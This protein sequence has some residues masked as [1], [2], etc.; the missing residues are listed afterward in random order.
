MASALLPNRGIGSQHARE[1]YGN[2]PDA[3]SV[4]HVGQV[5]AK[6]V[7]GQCLIGSALGLARFE[8]HRQQHV[9]CPGHAFA[10]LLVVIETLHGFGQQR[11]Q[12]APIQ[13]DGPGWWN[14]SVLTCRATRQSC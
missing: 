2:A 13:P 6:H 11:I 3:L 12:A 8:V 1:G 4:L 5:V 7:V 10:E 14:F 9:V